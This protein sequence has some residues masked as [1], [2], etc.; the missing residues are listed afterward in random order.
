MSN[1]TMRDR[2]DEVLA[3]LQSQLADVA[4][5][6]KKQAALRVEGRA[7]EGTVEVTVNARGQVVNVVIDTSYLDEH[8]FDELGGHVLQA[9]QA[10]VREAGQQVAALLAPINQRDKAFPALSDIV[11]DIT[12]LRD[13][14]PAGL[15]DFAAGA[16]WK[17]AS[18]VSVGGRDDD[19]DDEARFPTVRR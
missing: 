17:K 1:E 18:G 12:Q 11:E 9:A 13:A 7:A 2:L 6:Q 16:P 10:A 4:A 5:A 3:G 8:D 19:G 14:M 15:D